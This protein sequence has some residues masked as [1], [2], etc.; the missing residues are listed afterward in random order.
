M[1]KLRAEGTEPFFVSSKDGIMQCPPIIPVADNVKD[2]A[3]ILEVNALETMMNNFIN[4]QR[5][6]NDTVNGKLESLI[7]SDSTTDNALET[8]I[9]T[10]TYAQRTQSDIINKKL[11]HW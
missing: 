9:D 3:V 2:E 10:L 6:Q 7:E 4:E 5:T 11:I 1:N 8:A